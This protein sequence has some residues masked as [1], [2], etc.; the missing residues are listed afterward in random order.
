MQLFAPAGEAAALYRRKWISLRLADLPVFDLARERGHIGPGGLARHE[1]ML[2]R[3]VAAGGDPG[4]SDDAGVMRLN[5]RRLANAVPHPADLAGRPLPVF[6]LRERRLS[7]AKVLVTPD[8][9]C[10][11]FD[12]ATSGRS[13]GHR[14][15][16]CTSGWDLVK[17]APWPATR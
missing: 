8:F 4:S 16:R 11:G 12:R 7:R 15:E 3:I 1:C 9:P 17:P 10:L 13:H 14:S 5:G 6:G 2:K